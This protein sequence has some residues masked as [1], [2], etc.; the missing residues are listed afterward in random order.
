MGTVGGG[1]AE[2]LKHLPAFFDAKGLEVTQHEADLEGR[3]PHPVFPG[4]SRQA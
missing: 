4:R 2:P 3:D 1:P